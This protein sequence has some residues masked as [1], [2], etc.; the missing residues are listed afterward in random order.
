MTRTLLKILFPIL[1]LL[2]APAQSAFTQEAAGSDASIFGGT[3]DTDPDKDADKKEKKKKDKDKEE[4]TDANF[5]NLGIEKFNAAFFM[6]LLID[7]LSMIVLVR[8]IYYPVYKRRDHF[9]TFFMFNLTIFVIT[10]LLNNKSS[11]FSTGA[12]FGLFAVF[13]LLRYRTEDISARDMTYLFTVIAL[14]LISS[15]NKGNVLE[16]VIINSI[17]VFA[18]FCLD[19]N[20]LMKTEFVKTIQYE[21]IELIRPE[22]QELLI[23]DLEKRT[24]LKI[25]KVSVGRVDFLRDTAAIKVYYY[26]SKNQDTGV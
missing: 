12:A 10:F 4:V 26:E 5:F 11:S 17:I 1:I 16:I 20:V 19:G 21:N 3:D 25:H 22:N 2:F 23:A 18:A 8:C 6:R 24:G 9:F 7:L 15:V 14:G 13:S